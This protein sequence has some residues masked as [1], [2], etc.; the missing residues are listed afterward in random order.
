M[1][2]FIESFIIKLCIVSGLRIGNFQGKRYIKE[3]VIQS[4]FK[5]FDEQLRFVIDCSESEIQLI[6]NFLEELQSDGKIIYGTHVSS[7]A[8][9]T[10]LVSNLG[11]GK[12]VHF[13]D[14]GDGGY[15]HAAKMLKKSMKSYSQSDSEK[16][17]HRRAV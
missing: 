7:H 17:E 9:M 6:R 3:T 13:I 1:S 15:A 2:I 10:C 16:N 8:L 4:D 12:H 5:K 11:Q 14:G